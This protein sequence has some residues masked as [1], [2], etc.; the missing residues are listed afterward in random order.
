[1]P[2]RIVQECRRNTRKNNHEIRIGVVDNVGRR[3]H[4]F[5]NVAAEHDREHREHRAETGAQPD[6]VA[7]EAAQLLVV[8]AAEALCDRNRK[9]TAQ[10][11]AEADDQKGDGARGTDRGERTGAEHAPDDDRVDHRI[12]LLE[13]VAEKQR[14]G[15]AENQLHRRAVRHFFRH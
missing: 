4:Q 9:A 14:D 8:A 2:E 12:K 7:D 10:A 6:R 3:A 1:M 5:E 11:E 13:N 15:K